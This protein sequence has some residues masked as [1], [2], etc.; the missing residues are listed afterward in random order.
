MDDRSKPTP[1][2]ELRHAFINGELVTFSSKVV[3]SP[4]NTDS[5]KAM[6]ARRITAAMIKKQED[7]SR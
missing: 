4:Y 6:N 2:T 5:I 1:H 7:E 3:P